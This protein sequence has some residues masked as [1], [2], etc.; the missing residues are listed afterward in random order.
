MKIEKL[1]KEHEE[2]VAMIEKLK[3]E[4][5]ALRSKE[6]EITGKM[7]TAAAAGD[8]DLFLSLKKEREEAQ[9]RRYVKESLIKQIVPTT[10]EEAVAAWDEYAKSYKSEFEK[11]WKEYRKAISALYSEY[12]SVVNCQND[13]LKIREECVQLCGE[14]PL[15]GSICPTRYAGFDM[16]VCIENTNAAS[17][18]CGRNGLSAPDALFFATIK[19]TKEERQAAFEKFWPVIGMHRSV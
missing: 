12:M 1:R 18:N 10:K 9:D 16:P 13:A 17:L 2:R 6:E 15:A 14:E 4:S 7:E 8:E 3:K 11:K 19:D 5:D